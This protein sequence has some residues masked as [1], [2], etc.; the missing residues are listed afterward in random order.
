M[1]VIFWRFLFLFIVFIFG[2]IFLSISLRILL[3]LLKL[4][5]VSGIPLIIEIL[6]WRRCIILL[7]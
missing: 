4:L 7:L 2:Q 6:I 5:I 3:T 1:V